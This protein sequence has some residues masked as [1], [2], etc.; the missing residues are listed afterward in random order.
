MIVIGISL[1]IRERGIDIMT[2][3]EVV[4]AM[5]EMMRYWFASTIGAV[6]KPI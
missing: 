2:K 6:L 3:E 5:N 4:K 1:I